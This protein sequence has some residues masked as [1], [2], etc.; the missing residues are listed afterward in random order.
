MLGEGGAQSLGE[1]VSGLHDL[2]TTTVRGGQGGV[3]GQNNS[4]VCSL[5]GSEG[6]VALTRKSGG[7]TSLDYSK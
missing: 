1:V 4:Q 5:G 6:A 2:D 7:S 3:K